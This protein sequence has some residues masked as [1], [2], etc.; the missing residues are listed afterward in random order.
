MTKLRLVYLYGD[1]MNLY[2]DRGNIIALQRRAAW[3]GI[4][5]EVVDVTVGD[6]VDPA[7]SDLFF[8]GGGQDR[9]QEAVSLDLVAGNG[10]AVCEAVEAGAGLLAVC[11]G[12]QLLG[13]YFR[14]GEGL[15]I[16]GVGLFDVATVAGSARNVGNVVAEANFVGETHTL[17]GFENH[18][19]RTYVG[20]AQPAPPPGAAAS[21]SFRVFPASAPTEPLARVVVGQGNNG[22]DRTEGARYGTA[23]GTYLHGP[24]LPKNPWLADWLLLAGLRRQLGADATLAPLDDA[25]ELAAHTSVVQLVRQRGRV[26]TSIR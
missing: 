26:R 15:M 5:L 6:R 23:V 2:G 13:H 20:S 1:L 18:S 19:G 7:T 14:T 4:E 8:F 3:R 10:A 12:Y 9:E 21:S 25:Q 16:A 24:V 17:V 11:G 22:E